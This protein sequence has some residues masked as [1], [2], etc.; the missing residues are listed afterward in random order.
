MNSTTLPQHPDAIPILPHRRKRPPQKFLDLFYEKPNPHRS[1]EDL[2]RFAH[3]DV[4]DFSDRD[5]L[6]ERDAVWLRLILE[7]PAVDDW[8]WERH[9]RLLAEQEQR[10]RSLATVA[11][12][13]TPRPLEAKTV[14]VRRNGKEVAL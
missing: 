7:R 4:A 13:N 12:D 6:M 10:R 9:G 11:S 5:L 2:H 8:L 3:R 14:I 1:L